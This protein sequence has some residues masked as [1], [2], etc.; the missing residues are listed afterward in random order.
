MSNRIAFFS[1]GSDITEHFDIEDTG[2]SIFESHYNIAR[3]HHIPVITRSGEEY[4][5]QRMRWGKDFEKNAEPP[6]VL[7][8]EEIEKLEKTSKRRAIIPISGFYIW[9]RDGKKDH[10]FFVRNIDNSLLYSA[11]FTYKDA[12]ND[13][14]Y[15]E[16][17]MMES[18]TLIRPIT[19]KMPLIL[20]RGHSKKW[21]KEELDADKIQKVAETQFLITD[22]TVHRVSK[23]LNDLSKNNASL[24][25]PIPK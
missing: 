10:P 21:L 13:F 20:K 22:L 19:E 25:Q 16:I 9:K 3:G 8:G 23:E 11:G 4:E 12:E 18:N 14:T 2:E 17:L 24:I 5:L 1:D 15:V 6:E 7:S